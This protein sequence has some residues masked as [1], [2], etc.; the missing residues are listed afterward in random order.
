M[1]NNADNKQQA[2]RLPKSVFHWLLLPEI[3]AILNNNFWNQ[4]TC[5]LG[6]SADEHGWD[7]HEDAA[8]GGHVRQ[9]LRAPRRLTAQY[10]LKVHLHKNISNQYHKKTSDVRIKD[11][12]SRG[13][14]ELCWPP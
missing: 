3:E 5:G 9:H 14:I 2:Q 11:G 12:L 13:D 4:V 7:G 6:D 10:A 8:D 1:E